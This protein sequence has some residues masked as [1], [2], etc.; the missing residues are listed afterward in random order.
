MWLAESGF[1]IPSMRDLGLNQVSIYS[2]SGILI[3]FF[4][5]YGEFKYCSYLKKLDLCT[6]FWW[7]STWGLIQFTAVF[8]IVLAG[9]FNLYRKLMFVCAT[10]QVE[11]S[12][13]KFKSIK[14]SI[15]VKS[16]KAR[17]TCSMADAR[18]M[19]MVSKGIQTSYRS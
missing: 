16:V 1:F 8:R 19:N 6:E 7:V 14:C 17:F 2:S 5:V 12:S 9:D 18:G 15:A 11:L 3:F 4:F 10:S 13:L